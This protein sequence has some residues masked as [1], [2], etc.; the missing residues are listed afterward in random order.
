MT[1]FWNQFGPACWL[2]RTRIEPHQIASLVAKQLSEAGG[3]LAVGHVRSMDEVMSS[4]ISRQNFNMLLLTLFAA[5]ALVLAIVG[6]YGVM[7]YTIAQ[8]SQEIGVRMALGADR[9]NIRNLI[10]RQG[11]LLTIIGI[12]IGV[13]A[14][15]GLVRFIASFLFGVT[16]WDPVVFLSVP[17]L[18]LG[19]ALL[20]VWLPARRAMRVDPMQA[21]RAE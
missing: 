9:A 10:L 12:S 11:M 17:L 16:T 18:L 4:S 7:S 19:A 15:F 13:G 2:V 20:A 6:I 14:A 1:A 3:G 5:S 8:R 21:L